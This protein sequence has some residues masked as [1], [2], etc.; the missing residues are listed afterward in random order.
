MPPDPGEA[1]KAALE[2]ID[3]DGD[4]VRDDI[5]RYI[6]LNFPDSAKTRAALTQQAKTFQSMLIGANDKSASMRNAMESGGHWRASNL[7]Y[8]QP[9]RNSWILQKLLA[10]YKRRCSIREHVVL[11][12]SNIVSR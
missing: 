5:Q 9:I 10:S 2:G 8:N 12:T 6:A 11:P 7:Y 3:S 4:G 1:G